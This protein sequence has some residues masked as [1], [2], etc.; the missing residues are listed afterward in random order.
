MKTLLVQVSKV[1]CGLC[2]LV[3]GAF[4]FLEDAI[5]LFS[6]D[7]EHYFPKGEL[8]LFKLSV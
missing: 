5:S 2:A 6:K 7:F 4:A 1:I 8:P 3:M